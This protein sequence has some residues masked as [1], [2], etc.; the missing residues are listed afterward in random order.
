MDVRTAGVARQV[1]RVLA[2]LA[3]QCLP[4]HIV[5]WSG[6]DRLCHDLRRRAPTARLQ[7][8]AQVCFVV[9]LGES[10]VAQM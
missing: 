7:P 8:D 2:V 9:L 1:L 10:K 6:A 3:P 4:N 5:G